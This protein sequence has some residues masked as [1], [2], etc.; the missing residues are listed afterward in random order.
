M[1]RRTAGSKLAPAPSAGAA[2]GAPSVGYPG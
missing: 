1:T 2:A